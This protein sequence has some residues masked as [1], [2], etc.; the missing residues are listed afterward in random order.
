MILFPSTHFPHIHSFLL[1]AVLLCVH[2]DT[3]P[4]TQEHTFSHHSGALA[5]NQQPLASRSMVSLEKHSL[6]RVPFGW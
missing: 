6:F 4:R 3:G 1:M 2:P 5:L